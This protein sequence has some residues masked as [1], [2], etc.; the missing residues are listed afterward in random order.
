MK[1]QLK[2]S[3][4]VRENVKAMKAYSSAR[5]EFSSTK[6]D[7]LFLDANE[8][9]FDNKFNR[10]PD[11]Y[12][13]QLKEA[14]ASLKSVSTTQLMLGN[15]SDEVLD[16]IF[17]AFCEPH[18]DQVITM[19][20]T[21]GMYQV[22]ANLNAIEVVK[23]NLT[24]SFQ[25]NT[26]AVFD[27]ITPAT[28]LIFICSPNN[29]SGNVMQI[30]SIKLLLEQ[31]KGLVVIDEAY[32]D[33]SST[34]SFI[35]ELQIY[36]N[37]IVTQTFSKA[38]GHA[39]IRLGVCFAHPSIINVLEKIKPPYNVNQLTQNKALEVIKNYDTVS[40]Q[41]KISTSERQLLMKQ[42]EEISFIKQVFPSDAN[43][44]LCR[45]DDANKRYQELL[46]LGIIVRNRNQEVGCENCLRIS[47]GTPEQN[48]K[49]MHTLNQLD[50]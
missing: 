32:I 5:D 8:S 46:D 42:L 22:L 43:F 44:I 29:P 33:Y 7:L 23:V 31:F 36:D 12:Q 17:R 47:I 39:A 1:N 18:Q 48:K 24:E 27:A 21:Y 4:L 30:N 45:V 34:S 37:L 13:L 41:V 16:L 9:P 50:L 14:I 6:D 26:T 28:K 25:I 49:L 19:P 10:Y 35:S 2:L 15:G 11:P 40:F 20:P 3:E 38:L